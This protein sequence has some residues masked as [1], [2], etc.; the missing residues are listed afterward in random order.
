MSFTTA[1]SLRYKREWGGGEDMFWHQLDSSSR[2]DPVINPDKEA[3][4]CQGM[5]ALL[6][7]AAPFQTCD[8]SESPGR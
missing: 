4:L 5:L 2:G 7:E 6:P 1:D 8:L 3:G